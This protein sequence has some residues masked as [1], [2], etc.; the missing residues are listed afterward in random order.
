[1]SHNRLGL[2]GG[3]VFVALSAVACSS[4]L[5]PQVDSAMI[6]GEVSLTNE[7]VS[8]LVEVPTSVPVIYLAAA[9]SNPMSSTQIRVRWFKLPTQLLASEDFDGRHGDSNRFDFDSSKSLSSLASR[10]E[11][12]GVS[13]DMGEYRAEVW[14][15]GKLAKT[16]FFQVVSDAEA[17]QLRA[18][19]TVKSITFS[20]SADQ[21]RLGESRLSFGR[22]TN[23]IYIQVGLD[24][25]LSGVTIQTSVRY[26]KS[27]QI[28]TTFTTVPTG[29]DPLMFTLPRE[30]FGRFW[31][32]KL[33]PVGTFEVTVRAG[34]VTARTQTF[35]IIQ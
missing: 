32:D 33:W 11:R 31:S 20:D 3:I 9:V 1:M 19:H 14:L 15:N 16:V 5:S 6:A 18:Q 23:T 21:G 13:W 17:E 8:R 24:T 35:Q 27:D 29:T 10:L 22:S 28:I 25:T 34:G 26:V 30:R 7:P 4:E 12:P 2:F